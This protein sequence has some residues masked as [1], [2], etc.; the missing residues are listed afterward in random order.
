MGSRLNDPLT[1]RPGERPPSSEPLRTSGRGRHRVRPGLKIRTKLLLLVLSLLAIPWM[2]Y[3]SVREMEKFLL[4]GQQHALE[5]T[6]EGIA[7]LLGNR[8][9]L[10]DPDIGVPEVMG[11][12]FDVLPTELDTPLSID[13][14]ANEWLVALEEARDYTSAG[15]LECTVDYNPDSLAVR[16]GLGIHDKHVYAFF[17]I[18]DNAIIFRDPELVRLDKSDQLRLTVQ[19]LGMDI[20]RYLLTARQQGRMSVY[21]MKTDWRE[22]E[23][24]EALKDISATIELTGGGYAIKVRIPREVIGTR[25]RVKFDVIDVDDTEDRTIAGTISTDPDPFMHGLGQV[26]LMTPALAKLVEPLYISEASIRVWDRDFRLRAEL[27]SIFPEPLISSAGTQRATTMLGRLER[28]SLELYD[29]ILRQPMGE[30]EDDVPADSSGEDLRIL[31]KVI[32][33]G[34]RL[35]ERRRYGNTKLIVSSLPIWA[36]GEIQGAILIKQSGNRLLALQHETLRRFTLL[37]LGVFLF[38]AVVILL[39]ASRL[40]YRVGKLQRETEQA[41]TPE[42]RLLKDRIRSGTH[43]AD[44]LGSLTRSVSSMLQNLSQ[45]TQYLEKLPDTL[46]HE[47]HNPLNVVN[48]S[49]ENLQ[50]SRRELDDDKYLL[51]AQ[52]G[53]HRLRSILT[54]LTE[55]AN[56]KDALQQEADHFEWFDMTE[57]VTGCVEGYQQVNPERNIMSE[58]VQGAMYFNGVPDRIA[59]LLDKLIDNAL[60]FG[61]QEGSIVVG[62]RGSEGFIWLSVANEGSTLPAH[63]EDRLFDPMVSSAKDAGQTNLGLG[64][65][66]V[67]LIAEFHGGNV[68]AENRK[69]ASGVEV[70]ATLPHIE[71]N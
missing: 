51:R 29:W 26:R 8:K 39:F 28:M 63:L 25:A 65:Y 5:L 37:F 54:S 12:S 40:T 41:T 49:L 2:G 13:A 31:T 32:N 20:R 62:L 45:Y 48:S 3:K 15:S 71:K 55:A 42:G 19:V 50:Y 24:G 56:L 66:I 58:V 14:P 21:L 59:Q 44:E 7:S 11:R 53:V 69:Y 33:N 27:G 46:A 16:H 52:K 6:T 36:E 30:L 70:I 57:L 22:P 1:A 60:R 9:E 61:S 67:R 34:A 23:T 64:L 17:D 18:S 47:M 10:F 43:A 38:L 4:D 68:V 35:S